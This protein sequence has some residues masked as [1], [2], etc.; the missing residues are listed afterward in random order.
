MKKSKTLARGNES[1][2]ERLKSYSLAAGSIL[3]TSLAVHGQVIYTD[4]I[5]DKEIGG[6]IP[7]TFPHEYVDTLDLNN[8]GIFDFKFSVQFNDSLGSFIEQVMWDNN[9]NNL[10]LPYTLNYVPFMLKLNCDDSIPFPY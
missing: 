6:I 3:A 10:V 1:L 9:P 5:P 4:V 7:D 2:G 8:D